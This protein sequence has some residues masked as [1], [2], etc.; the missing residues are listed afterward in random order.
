MQRN[1]ACYLH[2]TN[3]VTFEGLTKHVGEGHLYIMLILFWESKWGGDGGGQPYICG[4]HGQWPSQVTP[5][6]SSWISGY[7]R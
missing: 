2:A 5:E 7:I 1:V 4:G 6:H 3:G